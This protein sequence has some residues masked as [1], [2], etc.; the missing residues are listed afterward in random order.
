MLFKLQDEVHVQHSTTL[1]SDIPFIEKLA[2]YDKVRIVGLMTM[3]PHI[4]D[5]AELREVFRTLR[6][7]RDQISAL[8]LSHAPCE[9]LSMGMSNDYEIAVEEGATHIRVGS[10]LVEE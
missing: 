4:E 1:Y 2:A 5:E 6:G 10:K 7:L 3:A 8:Q 9:Y